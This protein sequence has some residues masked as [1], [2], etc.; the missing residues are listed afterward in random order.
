MDKPQTQC[1]PPGPA[2]APFVA[3]GL[4]RPARDG[5]LWIASGIRMVRTQPLSFIA[6]GLVFV[7]LSFMIELLPA[8]LHPILGSLVETVVSP[9][10]SAGMMIGCHAVAGGQR[11]ALGHLF[12]GFRGTPG[13]LALFGLVNL[14][15][16]F[17]IVAVGA[18]LILGL[19]GSHGLDEG[20]PGAVTMVLV[21]LWCVVL[22]SAYVML[23]CYGTPLIAIG[24]LSIQAALRGSFLGC[25]KNL[26]ALSVFSALAIGI[27]LVFAGLASALGGFALPGMVTALASGA[28]VGRL[29]GGIGA[30]FAA[31][32]AIGAVAVPFFFACLYSSY[33]GIY[34]QSTD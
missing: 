1:L 12:C 17:V 5:V 19:T 2:A 28:P 21:A 15:L 10:L 30:G 16:L 7:L 34:Y 24:G 11:L 20:G 6:M 32:L 29:F 31:A 13:R 3:S 27:A 25:W 8:M 26:A 9:L 4:R 33:R 22:G 23:V 14:A 18:V